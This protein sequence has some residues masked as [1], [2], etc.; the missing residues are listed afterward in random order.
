M[1]SIAV[2]G[3]FHLGQQQHIIRVG[4]CVA[5][6]SRL[7]FGGVSA[8]S[9]HMR[10]KE[11]PPPVDIP[12]RLW[13]P[14]STSVT[15]LCVPRDA[16]ILRLRR[17]SSIQST[18]GGAIPRSSASR[19]ATPPA[20]KIRSNDLE[21]QSS[22]NGPYD[23][24]RRI[25]G[26]RASPR[27]ETKTQQSHGNRV[28]IVFSFLNTHHRTHRRS[29]HVTSHAG[30]ALCSSRP[31]LGSGATSG[32][33]TESSGSPTYR[34]CCQPRLQRISDLELFALSTSPGTLPKKCAGTLTARSHQ[35]PSDPVCSLSPGRRELTEESS[36]ASR[37]P[38]PP[39]KLCVS[40]IRRARA[41]ER[42]VT[43]GT[44]LYHGSHDGRYTIRRI[45]R[46]KMFPPVSTPTC[47]SHPIKDSVWT[48]AV[49]SMVRPARPRCESARRAK[50]TDTCPRQ[51]EHLRVTTLQYNLNS[52]YTSLATPPL[53]IASRPTVTTTRASASQPV[54]LTHAHLASP[55]TND[56]HIERTYKRVPNHEEISTYSP[57]KTNARYVSHTTNIRQRGYPRL[58]SIKQSKDESSA[59]QKWPRHRP[60]RTPRRP[61]MANGRSSRPIRIADDCI[62]NKAPTK[63]RPPPRST[64]T[65]RQRVNPRAYKSPD[66]IN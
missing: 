22:N 7:W 37:Q 44:A 65:P 25:A 40:A 17:S 55:Q 18:S 58:C 6:L 62:T 33:R 26:L 14:L 38:T 4:L 52:T 29:C 30:S 50:V 2:T 11:P 63:K 23:V 46:K 66:P 5:S 45:L 28:P 54:A 39:R 60:E 31:S 13:T 59:S 56:L 64:R 49:S 53:S 57:H 35:D 43:T 47:A 41:R 36:R 34:R 61:S 15:R 32:T 42:T 19:H 27:Q 12:Y 10:G 1:L 20:G 9:T 21:D 3:R 16:S 51:S 24:D 8:I 48:D